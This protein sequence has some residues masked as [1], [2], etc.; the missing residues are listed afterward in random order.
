[1]RLTLM[2][3]EKKIKEY[4]PSIFLLVNPQNPTGRVFTQDELKNNGRY[5]CGKSGADYIR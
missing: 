4:K 5:L 2:I 1:M 3:F